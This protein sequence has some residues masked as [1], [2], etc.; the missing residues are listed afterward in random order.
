MD[1]IKVLSPFIEKIVAIIKPNDTYP[2]YVDL[3]AIYR[4]FSYFP[5][6]PALAKPF[7]FS[8]TKLITRRSY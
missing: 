6:V 7:I 2:Q 3:R 8:V 5:R 4:E 1:S